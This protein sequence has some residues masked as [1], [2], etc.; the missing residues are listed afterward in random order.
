MVEVIVSISGKSRSAD[1]SGACIWLG[2]LCSDSGGVETL[3]LLSLV[4]LLR[5][6]IF[7]L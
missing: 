5:L 1:S 6:L 7:L 3:V 4:F 2:S